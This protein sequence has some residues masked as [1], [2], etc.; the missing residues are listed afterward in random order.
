MFWY[1]QH[2]EFQFMKS[3]FSPPLF[4]TLQG[5]ITTSIGWYGWVA[6]SKEER[7]KLLRVRTF[8]LIF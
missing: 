8:Y 6:T 3:A 7:D 1:G 5:T 4:V 2:E